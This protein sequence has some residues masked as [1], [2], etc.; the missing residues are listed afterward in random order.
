MFTYD[1]INEKT[2]KN[3]LMKKINKNR[4]AFTVLFVTAIISIGVLGKRYFVD[5]FE[6]KSENFTYIYY[7]ILIVFTFISSRFFIEHFLDYVFSRSLVKNILIKGN[8]VEG[9]WYVEWFDVSTGNET[10]VGNELTK[11]CFSKDLSYIEEMSTNYMENDEKRSS[12]SKYRMHL[13]EDLELANCFSY[14]DGTRIC[15]ASSRIYFFH[16]LLN[17]KKPD[18]Y[19]AFVVGFDEGYREKHKGRPIELSLIEKYK[20]KYGEELWIKK[21]LKN[22]SMD[23]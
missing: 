13:H 22:K 7:I 20:H 11:F 15:F 12:T 10:Y 4:L 16:S 5:Y 23:F 2:I 19:I 21:L 3:V 17:K 9:F 18:E 1:L 14:I 8:H 6:I